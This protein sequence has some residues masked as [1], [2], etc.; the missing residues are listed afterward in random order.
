MPLHAPVNVA[1]ANE[2]TMERSISSSSGE[3]NFPNDMRF[4]DSTVLTVQTVDCS[5]NLRRLSVI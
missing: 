4:K 5:Y 1:G 3:K 2:Q